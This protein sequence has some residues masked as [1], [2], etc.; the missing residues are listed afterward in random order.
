VFAELCDSMGEEVVLH[1][2]LHHENILR[3]D[4]GWVAIDPKGVIGER[5]YETGAFIRNRGADAGRRADQLA[6][7]LGLDGGR[8]RLWSW[9]QA[10]LAA[11]WAAEDGE[12]PS[13][14]FAV[15]DRLDALI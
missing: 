1:G 6:E 13:H 4:G 10:H 9:A 7:T 15:A 14:W 8:I 11:A 3:S 12:D 5:E 2:D